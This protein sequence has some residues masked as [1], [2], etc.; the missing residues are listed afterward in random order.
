MN[1][2]GLHIELT[3]M[4]T[5]KCPGC[6]RTRFQQQWPQHWK[7]H[8]LSLESLQ[9]FL[10]VELKGLLVNLCGNDGDCIYHPDFVEILCWF[11]SQGSTVYIHTNGSYK[12]ASWW[13]SVATL[14]G[15]GDRVIFAIDGVP[16]NFA[17]YRVNADWPSIE[18]GIQALA[19][20]P[21]DLVWKYIVFSYNQ[22]CVDQARDLSRQLGFD[23]FLMV[24]SD[25][26]DDQTHWLLPDR[27]FLGPRFDSQQQ[28]KQTHQSGSVDPRCKSQTDH[29]ITAAG[30]Y[31]PCC[32][33]ADY[34]F[35]YKTQWGKNK[36]LY[37]IR[38]NTLTQILSKPTTV[39]FYSSL[40]AAP[41]PECQF[42]C[43]A[44]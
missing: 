12:T 37:D 23:E 36:N 17:T 22:H 2:Q 26:F 33:L 43:P 28:W 14:L 21:A 5:L 8:N 32:Y 4:C 15:P 13:Q 11:K 1:I 42:N 9:K 35:Y 41:L 3:N 31:T 27:E 40:D 29:F 6:A 19:E 10:D 34:R 25:R 39:D 16:E 30:F 24:Q 38:S 7:N 20:S 18:S 44:T